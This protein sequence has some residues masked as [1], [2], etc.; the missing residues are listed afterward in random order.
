VDLSLITDNR[1]G[2]LYILVRINMFSNMNR[3]RLWIYIVLYACCICKL[4]LLMTVTLFMYD[5]Y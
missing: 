3:M 4:V 2:S 5:L 1:S